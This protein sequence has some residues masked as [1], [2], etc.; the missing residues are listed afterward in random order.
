MTDDRLTRDNLHLSEATNL[1]ADRIGTH[2]PRQLGIEGCAIN[3]PKGVEDYVRAGIA[4]A[5]RVAYRA[6]LAHFEAWG[7]TVPASATEVSSYLSAHAGTLAVAT[8]TRRLAAISV[9]HGACGLASPTRSLLVRATLRGIRRE[10]GTAQTQAKPLLR[11][12]LFAVLGAMG[13]SRRDVRDRALLLLG[14]AGG[15]RR[16]ELV[17]LNCSD[18]ER[19]RQGMVV[20]LRRSKTDQ[21]GVGRRI[22][23]PLGRT[24]HCPVTA[25]D[26]WL[27]QAEI[28]QGSIFRPVDRH[29]HVREAR[30]SREAV[31]IIVRQRLSEAG[32]DPSGFSGHS[33]RAGLVTSA[34]QAGVSTW[35]IRQQT[36]HSSD[37]MVARYVRDANLFVENAASCLL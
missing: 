36:G 35:K 12:N 3:C 20:A 30:L 28:K 21:E 8:L 31:S 13:N 1:L 9:A 2:A 18:I 29:G 32:L 11:E 23:I 6:D 10:H 26:G 7:G 27:A 4:P 25:L 22:G 24:R 37:T 19:V 15:F 17:S 14:F 5:T 16:S 33:L 34:A